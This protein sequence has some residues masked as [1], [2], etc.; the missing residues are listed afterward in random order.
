MMLRLFF[1]R[2]IL[3]MRDSRWVKRVYLEASRRLDTHPGRVN[4]CSHTRDALVKLGLGDYWVTQSPPAETEWRVMVREKVHEHEQH[5]WRIRMSTKP[6]LDT[7]RRW[8]LDLVYEPY[9]NDRDPSSRRAMTELRSGTSR[10]RVETGRYEYV[11]I[12]PRRSNGYAGRRRLK[13]EERVCELCY[14]GVED[15]M[16]FMWDCAAYVRRRDRLLG[17]LGAEVEPWVTVALRKNNRSQEMTKIEIAE[18]YRAL[19]HITQDKAVRLV[20]RYIRDCNR[21]R[22]SLS[23]NK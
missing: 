7:Y 6:K 12:T 13:R 20:T 9:L 1:W 21:I 10:L 4:W 8:K 17:D 19:R 11:K 14:A 22:R 16:H 2:K 5:E 3:C 18:R 23:I 15:E